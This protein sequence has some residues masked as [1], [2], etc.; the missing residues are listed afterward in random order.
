MKLHHYLIAFLGAP[1]LVSFFTRD[2]TILGMSVF[3]T[4]IFFWVK[5]RSQQSQTGGGEKEHGSLSSP[6]KPR[7]SLPSIIAG[8]LGIGFLGV[9][10]VVIPEFNVYR[11]LTDGFSAFN[12]GNCRE[13]VRKFDMITPAWGFVN[14]KAQT[15]SLL[16][17]ECTAFIKGTDA[18]DSGRFG[19]ALAAYI[20]F[21]ALYPNSSLNNFVPTKIAV[22]FGR[23][24]I[25]ELATNEVC[26][27]VALLGESDLLPR[28]QDQIPEVYYYCGQT[29]E[30]ASDFENSAVM[31]YAVISKYPNHYLSTNARDGFA[32]VEIELAKRNGAASIAQPQESGI[33]PFGVSVYIVR[34]DSPERIQIILR[35]PTVIVDEIA[36]CKTCTK[37]ESQPNYCPDKGS[38]GR[39]TLKPGNY[40]VVVKSVGESKVKPY[41]GS[42]TF[43]SG[44]EYSECFYIIVSK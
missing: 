1:F 44:S 43:R 16:R 12:Q 14:P 2:S 38:I 42:W 22:L 35:G 25:K 36:E 20:D 29:Y 24:S 27:R 18:E 23:V 9:I 34:N 17:Q 4:L 6:Q 37:F 21:S 13:A 32:R 15:V 11:N 5:T 7:L 30:A 8:V 3:I 28:S 33:A 40:D 10:I 39:Y 31:Y 41:Q 26:D 19:F